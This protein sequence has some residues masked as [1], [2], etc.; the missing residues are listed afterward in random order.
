M[1]ARRWS[2]HH[3]GCDQ[4]KATSARVRTRFKARAMVRASAKARYR[5]TRA[6]VG[7]WCWGRRG[8]LVLGW[9]GDWGRSW[10]AGWSWRCG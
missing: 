9:S 4:M 3:G 2:E 10:G 1:C 7:V 5:G 8:R 6:R